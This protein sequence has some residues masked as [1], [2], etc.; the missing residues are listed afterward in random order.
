[1]YINI[2]NIS[3]NNVLGFITTI[4]YNYNIS[5]TNDFMICFDITRH[6]YS[7]CIVYKHSKHIIK[8]CIRIYNNH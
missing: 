2:Q 5:M 6:I 8:Q 3:Y 4:K 7:I 1:M